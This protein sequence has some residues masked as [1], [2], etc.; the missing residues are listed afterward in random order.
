MRGFL[1]IDPGWGLTIVRVAMAAIFIAAGHTKFFVWGVDKVTDNMAKYGF[2]YPVV[3]AWTA[4]V[5]ELGGGVALLLGLFGRWLGL[6][7]AIQF[8]IA[9]FFVK[10]RTVGFSG[11]WTDLML[12]AT[13]LLLFLAGPGRVAVDSLWLE[14]TSAPR[15]VKRTRTA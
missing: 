13:G 2:P 1:G 14:K 12:L 15:Y 11:G 6:L 9:F 7:Y 8:A 3:F 10:L 5:L 4:T